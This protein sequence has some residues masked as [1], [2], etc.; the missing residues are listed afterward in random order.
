MIEKSTGFG[1]LKLGA[2][3]PAD[4]CCSDS[5]CCGPQIP[6]KRKL[7]KVGRNELCP[8]DSGKKYKKCCGKN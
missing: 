3:V 2:D 7:A 8:C 4:S 5:D 6:L 1:N